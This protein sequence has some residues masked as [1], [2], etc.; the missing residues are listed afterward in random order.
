MRVY[1]SASRSWVTI[2]ALVISLSTPLI[3]I[4]ARATAAANSALERS[5][6]RLLPLEGGS[7]F[8][9]MGG[10]VTIGRVYTRCDDCS[11]FSSTWIW[12]PFSC[13]HGYSVSYQGLSS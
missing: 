4:T 8:R 1:V 10:H 11:N 7:N 5:Y 2:I 6:R 13:L 12:S 3:T 9:D